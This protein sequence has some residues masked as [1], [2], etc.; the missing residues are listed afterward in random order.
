MKTVLPSRWSIASDGSVLS[1]ASRGSVLSIGSVGSVLSI[2][3]IGSFG[4]VLSIGSFLSVGSLLSAASLLSV[5]SWRSRRGVLAQ[6]AKKCQP[7]HIQPNSTADRVGVGHQPPEQHPGA[8]DGPVGRSGQDRQRP[9]P[10]GRRRQQAPD[11]EGGAPPAH[12][13]TR[14]QPRAS[15]PKRIAALA[16]CQRATLS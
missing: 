4:S 6:R 1:I 11:G 13:R 5:L 9:Q 2:G 14:Y 10:D 7:S 12:R 8:A 15:Q 16:A 3:S